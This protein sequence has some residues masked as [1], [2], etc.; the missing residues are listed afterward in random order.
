MPKLYTVVIEHEIVV[1]AES[2]S[3]AVSHAHEALGDI[4]PHDA[5]ISATEMRHLPVSW[6][7]DAIPFGDCSE[8]DPDRTIQGWI[9]QGA[10][11]TYQEMV[12]KL[13]AKKESEEGSSD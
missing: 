10:G 5:D 8:D 13:Q 7:L 2:E 1:V 3:E 11:V 6:G 4:D 9:D 12:K